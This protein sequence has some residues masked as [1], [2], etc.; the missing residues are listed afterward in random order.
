[1]REKEGEVGGGK[2]GGMGGE[3][4][5]NREKGKEGK[6]EIERCEVYLLQCVK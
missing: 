6:A 2:E 4:R 1:M 5:K 3:K